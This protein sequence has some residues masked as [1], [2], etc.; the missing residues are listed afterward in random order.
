MKQP[1]LNN[2]GQ[3]GEIVR[4]GF[5]PPANNTTGGNVNDGT[6]DY[7]TPRWDDIAQLWKENTDFVTQWDLPDSE[8]LLTADTSNER[9]SAVM[10]DKTATPDTVTYFSLMPSGFGYGAYEGLFTGKTISAFIDPG[11]KTFQ[12][13]TGGT[14][15]ANPSVV[16]VLVTDGSIA[17]TT[18]ENSDMNVHFIAN[19]KNSTLLQDTLN[20]AIIGGEGLNLAASNTLATQNFQMKGA[21]SNQKQAIVNIDGS[22]D[23]TTSMYFFLVG[24]V[25]LTLHTPVTSIG[26]FLTFVNTTGADCFVDPGVNNING[27]ASAITVPAGTVLRIVNL[28]GGTSF[29]SI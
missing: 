28:A 29:F 24:G 4:R 19:S 17:D 20:S 9:F 8:F 22:T 5:I 2:V 6:I 25:T 27:S 18:S 11:S 23:E 16:A 12:I 21:I 10:T 1:K 7:S 26:Q 13:R 14:G 3:G 15:V